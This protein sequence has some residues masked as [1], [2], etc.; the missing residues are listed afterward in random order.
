MRRAGKPFEVKSVKIVSLRVNGDLINHSGLTV[1]AKRQVN[2]DKLPANRAPRRAGQQTQ[3]Q[4]P[5]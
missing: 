3:R 4:R 5:E 1:G 2:L